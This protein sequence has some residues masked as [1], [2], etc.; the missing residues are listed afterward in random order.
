MTGGKQT[1]TGHLGAFVTKVKKGS[2]ADTVGQ[3][4]PGDEVLQWND[5][6]LQGK[7]SL[8]I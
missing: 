1:P 6:D 7:R 4:R 2:I 5:H 3:L 8:T